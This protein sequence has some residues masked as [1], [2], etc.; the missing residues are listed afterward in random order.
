MPTAELV[1]RD[2]ARTLK[3]SKLVEHPHAGKERLDAEQILTHVFTHELRHQ[4]QIQ[5]MLRL[6]DKPAPNAD[7][8]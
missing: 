2:A 3:A 6:L 4:G 7:W 1:L 8:I 5:A